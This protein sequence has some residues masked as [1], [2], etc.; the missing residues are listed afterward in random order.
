MDFSSILTS[1]G[2]LR[3]LSSVGVYNAEKRNEG[4]GIFAHFVAHQSEIW[5][6]T[7]RVVEMKRE[8]KRLSK[9]VSERV[10]ELVSNRVSE[11]TSEQTGGRASE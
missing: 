3:N 8:S 9:R 4:E 11:R 10:S 7:N 2:R 6:L 5:M 1:T